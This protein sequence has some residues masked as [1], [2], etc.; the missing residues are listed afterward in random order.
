MVV[1]LPSP[2]TLQQQQQQKERQKMK[3]QE[4]LREGAYLQAP[5]LG[6]TWFS[7]QVL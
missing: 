7:L 1:T 3:K 5:T 2:T 6:P 4:G